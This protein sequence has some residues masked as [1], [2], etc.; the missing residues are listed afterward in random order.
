MKLNFFGFKKVKNSDIVQGGKAGHQKSAG[1][2][3]HL[4]AD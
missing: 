3:R 2:R 4:C 1:A